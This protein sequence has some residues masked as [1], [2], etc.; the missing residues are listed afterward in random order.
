MA[1]L[2]LEA[3]TGES[4]L[5]DV[6]WE[7]LVDVSVSR[8]DDG[9]SVT[10]LVAKNFRVASDLG[11]VYDFKVGAHEWKWELQDT[12]PAGC[13]ELGI[14]ITPAPQGFLKGQTYHFGIQARTFDD[15]RPPKVIDQ[16]Q[17]IVALISQGT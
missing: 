9:G 3:V 5:T 12:E 15:S 4:N 17:T 7:I 13:Y 11:S 1:R 10:G 2:L 8:V 16:G 14:S 6:V